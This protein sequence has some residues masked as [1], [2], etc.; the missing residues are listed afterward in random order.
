LNLEHETSLLQPYV[1]QV[2][3]ILVGSIPIDFKE[4]SGFGQCSL[5]TAD[6]SH[7]ILVEDVDLEKELD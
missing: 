6:L 7:I 1:I 4:T 2:P 5:N 3:A